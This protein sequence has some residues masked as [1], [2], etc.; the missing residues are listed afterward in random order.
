MIYFRM[1]SV[2]VH[3]SEIKNQK[4]SEE[5]HM[6]FRDFIN[7]MTNLVGNHMAQKAHWINTTNSNIPIF[8]WVYPMF[9]Q[10]VKKDKIKMKRKIASMKEVTKE[11]A[12][13]QAPKFTVFLKNSAKWTASNP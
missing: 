4:D 10:M 8:M 11:R 2:T 7:V 5:M 12:S 1:K 13:T 3:F 6:K 9:S